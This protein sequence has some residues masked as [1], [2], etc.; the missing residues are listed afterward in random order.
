MKVQEGNSENIISFLDSFTLSD[1]FPFYKNRYFMPMIHGNK[2]I[3]LEGKK[4][5]EYRKKLK[6]IDYVDFVLWQKII[7]GEKITVNENQIQNNY[8]IA[9]PSE[10]I[11]IYK[12]QVNQRVSVPRSDFQDA[13]PFYFNWH[14]FHNEAGLFCLI[15]AKKDIMDEIV[16]LFKKLG[17]CG[18]G[19]DKNIGGGKF[20]VETE[21]ISIDFPSDADQTLLLS[22]LFQRK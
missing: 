6:N 14:Y 12:S 5:F 18:I 15:D 22:V 17:E 4:E 7:L 20:E 3:S 9:E 8:L 1:A 16:P 21:S 19:T 11:I 13:S 10:N 2:N